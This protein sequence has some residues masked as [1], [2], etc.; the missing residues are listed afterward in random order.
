MAVKTA[1]LYT[2]SKW[3]EVVKWI[4]EIGIW[5]QLRT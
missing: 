3:K 5:N 4:I 2:K 1:E